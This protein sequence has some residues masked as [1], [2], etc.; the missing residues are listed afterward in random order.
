M[1]NKRKIIKQLKESQREL[2]SGKGKKLRSLK[3]L[4]KERCAER[5]NYL[6]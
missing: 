6:K 5:I 4:K 1:R 2:A 3:D